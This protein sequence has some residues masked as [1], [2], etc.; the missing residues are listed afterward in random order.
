MKLHDGSQLY[1]KKV[2][3]DYNPTDKLAALRLLHETARGE[4]A[5]GVLYIE[6]DKHDLS[7]AEPRR[8]AAGDLPLERMRPPREPA[9]GNHGGAAV[10]QRGAHELPQ[11]VYLAAIRNDGAF[12]P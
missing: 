6:P 11:A 1:L 2:A 3:E 12:T 10:P 8:R 7:T 4:F 9:R 5:T